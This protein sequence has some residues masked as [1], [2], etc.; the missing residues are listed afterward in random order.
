MIDLKGRC[1]AIC[2]PTYDG[3]VQGDLPGIVLQLQ[4]ALVQRGVPIDY[5]FQ[6]GISL[7][8]TARNGLVSKIMEHPHITDVL[9]I[10][11]DIVFP[12]LA[13][14]ALMEWATTYD[15]VGCAYRMKTDDGS[16]YSIHFDKHPD[17]RPVMLEDGQLLK[18]TRLPG[19]FILI[20]KHVLDRL[21]ETHENVSF[22]HHG[23]MYR[24]IYDCR[25]DPVE[26]TYIGEDYAFCDKVIAEGFSMVCDPRMNLGHVGNKT[27]LGNL[28]DGIIEP[29]LQGKKTQVIG[30][31]GQFQFND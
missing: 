22:E 4:R 23:T 19:G 5:I 1:L 26:K 28:Y 15:V 30:A 11:S 7:I 25:Y 29:Q 3:R 27:F 17:G 24:N 14:I 21:W 31:P 9:F 16:I 10:D 6:P 13:P 20:R 8:T 18:C 12:A 2:I